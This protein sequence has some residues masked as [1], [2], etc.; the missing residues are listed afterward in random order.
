MSFTVIGVFEHIHF[1][2]HTTAGP[3][4]KT[5]GTKN[6]KKGGAGGCL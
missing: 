3:L 1:C 6:K 2:R 4:V 5:Q